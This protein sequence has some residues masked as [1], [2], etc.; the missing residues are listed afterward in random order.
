M[1][2]L[3]NIHPEQIRKDFSYI[4]HL[5]RRGHGY[6]VGPLEAELRRV[7][8]ADKIRRI[9]LIGANNLGWD[10]LAPE[11]VA[12]GFSIEAAFDVRWEYGR[13]A[14]LAV[15]CYPLQALSVFLMNHTVDVAVLAVPPE[16]A[17]DVTNIL[18]QGGVRAILNYVPMAIHVPEHVLLRSIDPVAGLLEIAFSV[19][20]GT[21]A[22]PS[23]PR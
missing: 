18:V 7:L 8:M 21:H 9:V 19:R 13:P 15:P 1:G 14:L 20:G 22:R 11:F 16:G 12:W 6:D 23:D 5:G 4:G 17:Q 2:D 3:L 10:N